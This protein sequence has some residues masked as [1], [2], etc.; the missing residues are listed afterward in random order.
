MRLLHARL[1]VDGRPAPGRA[2]R[3]G[4]GRDPAL[5]LR[6]SLPLRG[7]SGDHC[8]GAACGPQRAYRQT[9]LSH[10]HHAGQESRMRK[11]TPLLALIPALLILSACGQ[12]VPADKA[13]YVGD[14]RAHGMT[15]TL[16]QDG[17]VHYKRIKG[18]TTTSIDAPLR[19]F[20]G[21]NFVV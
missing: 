2:S 20:E 16:T 8:G 21:D 6:Q 3:P 13:A 4:R 12:P 1:R 18:K 7:L 14:W 19:R 17:A 9:G 15:L 5:S 10:R 11:K